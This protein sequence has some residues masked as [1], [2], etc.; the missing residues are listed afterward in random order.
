VEQIGTGI[1]A[2]PAGTLFIIGGGARGTPLMRRF[3][4]LCGGP[5]SSIVAV[6][7]ASALLAEQG[8]PM[9]QEL[10]DLGVLHADVVRDTG[11]TAVALVLGASGIY[12]TGGDQNLLRDRLAGTPLL[13]AINAAYARGATIGGTSAGAAIMSRVMLS[14][15]EL[16]NPGV[17][18]PDE[19]DALEAFTSI[20][21]G[22]VE[23]TE[24]FG[25]LEDCVVDQHFVRRKR[26]NRL[27]SVVLEHPQLL[28]VGIDESTTIIVSGGGFDVV[29]DGCVIVL[30]AS[31]A[32]DCAV[33]PAGNL[34]CRGV[35]LHV[36]TDGQ[37]FD[38]P[39]R[40]VVSAD[41]ASSCT[42]ESSHEG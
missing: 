32:S 20:R 3:V 18:S 42:R 35:A 6:P 25:F 38:I 10:R 34:S 8:E 17:E 2:A 39:G 33:S 37:H 19:G 27:V 1:K 29:G 14:G 5:G 11:S 12:F 23:T 40:A 7:F 22:N 26:F 16:R 15:R 28:G 24:G 21:A 36:L 30:D 9:R 4:D 31:H 41:S 13:E